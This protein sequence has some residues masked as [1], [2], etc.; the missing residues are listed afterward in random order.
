VTG[1]ARGLF[2]EAA[3]DL[4]VPPLLVR[5]RLRTLARSEA[6]HRA[7]MLALP[8]MTMIAHRPGAPRRLGFPFTVG[9]W[10]LERC[11]SPEAS[12]AILAREGVA[13]ALLS[14]LDAGMART[15]QRDTT[16]VIATALGLASAYGVEFLELDLGGPVERAFCIDDANHTGFHGNAL[17]APSLGHPFLFRLDDHGAWFVE[18][19]PEP[20]IG[21]RCAVGGWVETEAGPVLAVSAHLESAAMPGDRGAAFAGLLEAVEAE[22]EGRPVILGGDLNTGLGAGGDWEAE[23]LLHDA[24]RRGYA[25]HSGAGGETTTRASRITRDPPRAYKLDWILTRGLAT[26]S[27]RVVPALAPDGTVLSDHDLVTVEIAGRA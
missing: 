17:L 26:G 6:A 8:C 1:H 21:G 27:S 12:A 4:P 9:A 18:T 25:L 2:R 7:A 11:L 24:R 15:G 3:P 19:S 20:R 5:E 16:R 14:E 23:P 13:V 22:A 10:N